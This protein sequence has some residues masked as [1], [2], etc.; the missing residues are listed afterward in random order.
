ML[1]KLAFRNVKRQIGNYLIY[2]ITVALTVALM[3]AINNAIYS[4]QLQEYAQNIREMRTA[5]LTITIFVSLIVA[6]VLG[7]A[8]SFLL[9][10]RKREFGTYLTLGMTRGNILMIFVLETLIMSIAALIVGIV[11]G[12]FLYQGLM[13][14]LMRLLEMEFTIASYSVKGLVF[15][16]VLVVAMFLLSSFTSAMYLKKVSISKLLHGTKVVEKKVKHPV[17]WL[18][19]T[20]ISLGLIIWSCIA[21]YHSIHDTMI[22]ASSAAEATFFSSMAVLAVALIFFHIGLARSLVNLLLKNEKYRVKGTNTFTLRQLSGKLGANSVMAGTLAFL[23]A[24]AIVGANVS[25]VQ[26]MSNEVSLKRY[27]PFD[28]S[29][30]F[31]EEEEPG[32]PEAE[33]DQI[34]AEHVHILSKYQYSIYTNDTNYL[35]ENFTTWKDGGF[36]GLMDSFLKESD[37]NWLLSKLGMEPISLQGGFLILSQSPHAAECDFSQAVLNID[38]KKYPYEGMLNDYPTISRFCY[39]I[40]VVPDEA[41]DNMDVVD[42]CTVY[43]IE[44]ERYDAVALEEALSYVYSSVNST[45]VNYHCDYVIQEMVRM[46]NNS[47]SAILIISILYVAVVFVF[48]AL[49]ILALKTFS[50]LAEDRQRYL[51]LY[52]LGADKQMLKKAMFR[53]TFSFFLL[54]FVLPMLLNIPIGIVCAH[55]MELSGFGAYAGEVV[56]ITM[57]I[58]VV[59]TLVYFLY[60]MATYLL[61]KRNIFRGN[62]L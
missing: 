14:L 60:Y 12:L 31:W 33:A 28:I 47:T 20:L 27:Y 43:D 15:T 22:G 50:G 11:I 32:I 42:N 58:A 48:M 10:L 18:I 24:F 46:S 4:Q 53:Q 8:T 2:F 7:Y 35:H 51:M 62:M 61:C 25:F 30:S 41:V 57:A 37:F 54:P 17:F 59:V 36:A 26:K 1:A 5:L 19:V 55:I 52:H 40:A 29:A 34:I 6:F 38:G 56:V 3:F 45:Y 13:L 21:F 49:A 44:E 16:I 39:F 23:I 9:K